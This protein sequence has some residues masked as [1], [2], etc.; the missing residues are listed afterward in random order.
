MPFPPMQ[1]RGR[2]RG[3]A[4]HEGAVQQVAAITYARVRTGAARV[5]AGGRQLQDYAVISIGASSFKILRLLF[6]V[7]LAVHI[8]ACAFWKVSRACRTFIRRPAISP[9]VALICARL[10]EDDQY[11]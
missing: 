9:V 4:R 7:A 5:A 6:V 2:R 11:Q 3:S 1:V 8:F 10:V